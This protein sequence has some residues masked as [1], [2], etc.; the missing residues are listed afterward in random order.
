MVSPF[1][2]DATG[3][4]FQVQTGTRALGAGVGQGGKIGTVVFPTRMQGTPVVLL[5]KMA[6][7][8]SIGRVQPLR[9]QRVV[10]GSFQWQTT[11]SAGTFN[12]MALSPRALRPPQA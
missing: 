5:S 2:R 4:L 8:N 9:V 11:G 3:D 1:R 7:S 10:S 6:G 12:W